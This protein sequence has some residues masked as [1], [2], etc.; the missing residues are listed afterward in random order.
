MLHIQGKLQ[1]KE[2]VPKGANIWDLIDKDV[3]LA[4]I[5]IFKELKETISIE[6]KES[7]RTMS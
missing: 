4:I 3:K 5:N 6:L 1:P 7:M 2:H